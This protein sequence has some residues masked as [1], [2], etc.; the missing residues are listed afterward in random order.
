ME[1]VTSTLGL[2]LGYI[3]DET[4]F[5][6]IKSIFSRH[7]CLVND[8]I[9][10]QNC[11]LYVG[12]LVDERL[13]KT[14]KSKDAKYKYEKCHNF[15]NEVK[16]DIV[17]T[18]N[19]YTMMHYYLYLLVFELDRRYIKKYGKPNTK[20]IMKEFKKLDRHIYKEYLAYAKGKRK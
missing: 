17:S 13:C 19:N 3:K 9:N 20:T 12:A 10:V 16:A 11:M 15:A 18:Y 5:K 4:T 2:T 8:N 14:S 1:F 7:R 6:K